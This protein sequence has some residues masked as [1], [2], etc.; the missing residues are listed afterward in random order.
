M[1]NL[2]KRII[3]II[4]SLLFLIYFLPIFFIIA[5]LIILG[6]KGPILFKAMSIG[7]NGRRFIYY[8]FRTMFIDFNEDLHREYIDKL[9]SG[10][11]GLAKGNYKFKLKMDPRITPIGKFLRKYYLDEIPQFINVLKGDMSL[12]GPRPAFE[13]EVNNYKEWQKERLK[14]KPGIT[15]LWQTERINSTF[16]DF[17]EMIKMDIIYVRRKSILLDLKILFKTIFVVLKGEA[18]H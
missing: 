17:D 1:Y 8:K 14:V 18:G 15:G 2:I 6:S 11:L 9:I 16:I 13:F 3:D 10:D 7:K 5:I 12:I 4:F